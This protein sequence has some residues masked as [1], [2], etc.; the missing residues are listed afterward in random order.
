MRGYLIRKPQVNCVN[1]NNQ[2]LNNGEALYTSV[3]KLSE[4]L[5]AQNIL[6]IQ[7]HET[8]CQSN[9]RMSGLLLH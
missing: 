5:P 1:T 9:S 7:L 6:L 4:D 8:D 2:N 3:C